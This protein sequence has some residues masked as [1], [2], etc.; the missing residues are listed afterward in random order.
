MGL[1]Q[2][3]I[4]TVKTFKKIEEMKKVGLFQFLIGTVKTLLSPIYQRYPEVFQFLIGTVKTI[5]K[6][7]SG[8]SLACFNS[9]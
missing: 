7:S 5:H 4:G 1:F 6:F 9:S 2:F 3:L 8:Y